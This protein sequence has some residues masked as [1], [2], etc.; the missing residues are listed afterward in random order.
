MRGRPAAL[1]PAILGRIA[2]WADLRRAVHRALIT[3]TCG[4]RGFSRRLSRLHWPARDEDQALVA[5]WLPMITVCPVDVPRCSISLSCSSAGFSA[6]SL[7]AF[8]RPRSAAV[9]PRARSSEARPLLGWQGDDPRAGVHRPDAAA[10]PPEP[11]LPGLEHALH[12]AAAEQDRP[13]PLGQ[14]DRR[15]R[16]QRPPRKTRRRA[17]NRR[18]SEGQ[19]RPAASG[20]HLLFPFILAELV[21]ADPGG[22]GS[23][24]PARPPAGA[25]GR[26][27]PERI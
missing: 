7:A 6:A 12:S 21:P 13:L 9:S 18:V 8:I 10:E 25:V 4:F 22:G 16:G 14:G 17:G 3:R 23:P 5:P 20:D 26:D 27:E 1:D 11:V 19:R 24:E 15:T 2:V